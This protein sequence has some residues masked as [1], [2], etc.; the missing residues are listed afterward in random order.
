MKAYKI[1][2]LLILVLTSMFSCENEPVDYEVNMNTDTKWWILVHPSYGNPGIYLYNE[3]KSIIE[4]TLPLPNPNGSPHALDYDGE[5]LWIGGMETNASI[6]QLDPQDGEI[7]S[8]INN[9]RTEGI[10]SQNNYLFFDNYNT[11]KKIRKDGT[12]IEEIPTINSSHLLPDL[13]IDGNYLYYTRYSENQPIVKLNLSTG[14]EIFIP[15]IENIEV[16][17]LAINKD[18]LITVGRRPASEIIRFDKETGVLISSKTTNI[19]G[20]VTAIAPYFEK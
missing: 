19:N 14:E 4:R 18:E 5:F 16:N 15:N 11:V 7:I 2:L 1:L 8:Q 6:F 9:I 3:T 10:S 13:A 20:W 12:F 17:C